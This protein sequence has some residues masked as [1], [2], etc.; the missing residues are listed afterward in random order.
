MAV[1]MGIT[2]AQLAVANAYEYAVPIPVTPDADD[3]AAIDADDLADAQGVIDLTCEWVTRYTGDIARVP[4][5]IRAECVRRVVGYFRDTPRVPSHIVTTMHNASRGERGQRPGG[6]SYTFAAAPE[7]VGAHPL[8]Q[9][10]CMAIL[11][12]YKRRRAL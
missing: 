4:R 12:P 6:N 2:A 8:R 3:L 9:T 1:D 10:G 5:T 11:N 7:Y